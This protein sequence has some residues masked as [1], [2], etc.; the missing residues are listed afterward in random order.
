RYISPTLFSYRERIQVNE[1]YISRED[2][3]RLA[4]RIA[5]VI[6]E[7]KADGLPSPS[8]FEIETAIS[9]LYFKEQKCDV[10]VLETGM[11]GL[12]DATNIITTSVMEILVSISRDHMGFLG[13]TLAEIASQK[14]GII[15]PSTCVITAHQEK[16]AMSVIREKCRKENAVLYEVQDEDMSEIQYGLKEQRFLWHT[17]EG[18]REIAIHLSGSYQIENA[19]T[20][21]TALR[22]M[23]EVGFPVSVSAVKKGMARTQWRGRFTLLKE[24]PILLMDGAHNEDGARML[25]RSLKQYFSGKRIY[26][27]VGML[28]DKEYEKVAAM[29]A[30]YACEVL[31]VETPDN[32][33]ALSSEDLAKVW[34]QYHSHVEACTSIKQAVTKALQ[35]AGKEE[36]IVA[37]GSLSFLGL[38]EKCVRDLPEN[39]KNE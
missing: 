17:E 38:L 24:E 3:T 5:R 26:Y 18:P 29:T 13:N 1:E 12:E 20:A 16:E 35:R 30:P 11:G 9:F 23:K 6:E 27:I 14:A 28:A 19:K 2:F 33:R 4:N 32:P 22:H 34:K 37:F 10:V 7:M 15:K 8:P 21:L 39:I 31:T 36:V 25:C